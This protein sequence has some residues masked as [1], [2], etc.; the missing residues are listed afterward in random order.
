MFLKALNLTRNQVFKNIFI[1]D[2]IHK[3]CYNIARDKD[4]YGQQI[5]KT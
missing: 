2:F 3:L 5:S 1:V 4:I